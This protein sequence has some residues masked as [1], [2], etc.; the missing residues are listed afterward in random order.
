MNHRRYVLNRDKQDSQ[1]S[2]TKSSQRCREDLVHPADGQTEVVAHSIIRSSEL[3]DRGWCPFI[4]GCMQKF[5]KRGANLGYLKKR[6]VH[7]QAAT[8]GALE[9]SV[10]N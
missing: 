8:G 10:K 3:C 6:G 9:D 4:Q 1:E 2:G 7:L 5:C